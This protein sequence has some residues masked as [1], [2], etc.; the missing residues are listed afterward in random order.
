M[1]TQISFEMFS[2]IMR[3]CVFIVGSYDKECTFLLDNTVEHVAHC[4]IF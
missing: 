3:N 4:L 1:F 2:G